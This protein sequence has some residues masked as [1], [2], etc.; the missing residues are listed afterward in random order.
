MLQKSRGT[1]EGTVAEKQQKRALV[2]LHPYPSVTSLIFRVAQHRVS[3]EHFVSTNPYLF[4]KSLEVVP[5]F[6]AMKGQMRP[7]SPEL[8]GNLANKH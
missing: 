6:V 1:G 8:P 2:E 5:G 3:H 7:I 4:N